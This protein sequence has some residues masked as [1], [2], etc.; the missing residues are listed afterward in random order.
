MR[1]SPLRATG[2]E[3]MKLGYQLQAKKEWKKN[4]EF[5][6]KLKAS[7]RPQA[8]TKQKDYQWYK[9]EAPPWTL[10]LSAVWS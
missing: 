5:E 8:K 6:V 9:A 3:S 7:N 4:K 1:A 2:T 10:Y